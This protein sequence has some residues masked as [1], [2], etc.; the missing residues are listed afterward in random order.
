[1]TLALFPMVVS[2]ISRLIR[3]ATYCILIDSADPRHS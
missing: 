2:S 3:S 1:V